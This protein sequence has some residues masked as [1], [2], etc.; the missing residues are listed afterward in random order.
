M[1]F[2]QL[3]SIP[4]AERR[5]S[6]AETQELSTSFDTPRHDKKSKMQKEIYNMCDTSFNAI[7]SCENVYVA[8]VK[9]QISHRIGK[10]GSIS[11]GGEQLYAYI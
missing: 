7:F 2:N 10:I 11:L 3:E 1:D 5:E 6:Y 8:S 4:A 9:R